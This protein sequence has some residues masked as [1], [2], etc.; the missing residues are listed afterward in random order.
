[1]QSITA[2]LRTRHQNETSMLD[3]NRQNWACTQNANVAFNHAIDCQV[4]AACRFHDAMYLQ[5]LFKHFFT[6]PKF[7]S[8]VS[9]HD[10]KSYTKAKAKATLTYEPNEQVDG[11]ML[12]SK[13]EDPF[14]PC[15]CLGHQK[16][17]SEPTD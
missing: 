5:E 17:T 1:M 15:Y 8:T 14:V 9:S 6:A 3:A 16:K 2:S 4:V 13:A 11:W 12:G 10:S 7:T